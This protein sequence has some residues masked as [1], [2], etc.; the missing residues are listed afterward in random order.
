[1][2]LAIS[3][4]EAQFEPHDLARPF[5]AR[6]NAWAFLLAWY[7]GSAERGGL[8]SGC[9]NQASAQARSDGMKGGSSMT[10][11]A[12]RQHTS[13][14]PTGADALPTHAT[15]SSKIASGVVRLGGGPITLTSITKEETS[16]LTLSPGF[17]AALQ[18]LAPK[19]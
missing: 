15:T 9:S 11:L 2:W 5:V 16:L 18:G 10:M 4:R 8:S 19:K 12:A 6:H 17:H 13:R 1:M 7:T 3:S 14:S